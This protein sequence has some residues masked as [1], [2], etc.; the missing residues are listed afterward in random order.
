MSPEDS[1]EHH[2]H[3]TNDAC[4]LQDRNSEIL[5][6]HAALLH[7]GK[8]LYFSGSG[9]DPEKFPYQKMETRLWD[10]ADGSIAPV[11][12]HRKQ[13]DLFCAGHCFLPDG[14][15]LVAGGNSGY[16]W[17]QALPVFTGIKDTFVFE[18]EPEPGRWLWAA[19]MAAGRW[20]PT[21]VSL[22][23]G[24]ALAFSGVWD[25]LWKILLWPFSLYNCKVERWG[26]DGGSPETADTTPG[27]WTDLHAK[28]PM[29]YYPRVH[30]V[31]SGEILFVGQTRDILEF[32]PKT[33]SWRTVT[34]V[35]R[36]RYE[37]TSVLLPL[38]PD[39]G[40]R[41]RIL[42]V[43]GAWG[44]RWAVDAHNDA[45][46]LDR[47][48]GDWAWRWIP[49]MAFRRMHAN[50]TLLLDGRVLVTAGGMRGREQPI[51]ETELFDPRTETW[52]LGA[53]C[54]VGRTYHSVAVLLPDGRVWTGGGNLAWGLDELRIEL[55]TPGY[56]LEEDRPAIT[57]SPPSV[58][59]DSPFEVRVASPTPLLEASLVRPGSVTH[60][61]NVDQ[62]WV[63]LQV[64]SATKTKLELRSPPNAELAPPGWYLL[65]VLDEHRCPAEARWI[66][67]S[68]L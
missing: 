42:A 19:P 16:P 47:R 64:A 56:C 54:S 55:Y 52:R 41:A 4:I 60:S 61:F 32:N 44:Q 50:A 25:A 23:D 20:Y 49:P 38:R 5:P 22:P 9:N 45:A 3:R 48:G 63:G 65:T 68:A 33:A 14:R 15:L 66:R 67:L 10:P 13:R 11:P 59:Y 29:Y 17:S 40:Y 62:R 53:T 37:G 28:R 26:V 57:A 8:L 12:V 6:I 24:G 35:R 58:A 39:E 18:P 43:G 7:T 31:P 2:R 34:R 1:E 46:I 27:S 36:N 21:V 30:V 51:L